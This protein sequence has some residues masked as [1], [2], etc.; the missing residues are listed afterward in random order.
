MKYLSKAILENGIYAFEQYLIEVG[1]SK[2]D[3]NNDK[4][5]KYEEDY[6]KLKQDM[7]F[8]SVIDEPL[9]LDISELN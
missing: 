3:I 5:E 7:L 8:Y 4:L 6:Y 2:E 9:C 1:I